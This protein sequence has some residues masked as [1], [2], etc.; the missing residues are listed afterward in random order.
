MGRKS[1]EANLLTSHRFINKNAVSLF[2]GQEQTDLMREHER[3][4]NV[5]TKV[6][7]KHRHAFL[8]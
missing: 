1:S 7:H 8:S 4:T 6:L 5:L 3:V 2:M